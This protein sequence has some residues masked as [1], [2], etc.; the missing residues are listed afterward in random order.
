[1]SRGGGAVSSGQGF[2]RTFLWCHSMLLDVVTAT[3]SQHSHCDSSICIAI[4]SI[5]MDV[6]HPLWKSDCLV[7]RMFHPLCGKFDLEKIGK[8]S[9]VMSWSRSQ[10]QWLM[11]RRSSEALRDPQLRCIPMRVM[12][13]MHLSCILKHCLALPFTMNAFLGSVL[14]SFAGRSSLCKSHDHSILGKNLFG[15]VGNGITSTE[16]G[17]VKVLDII[18]MF[19][20]QLDPAL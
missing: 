13:V 4:W 15:A 9:P 7:H 18:K 14:Q 10:C 20:T 16:G 1:M 2:G 8:S 5:K 12:C 11:W 19:A 17:A 6:K 3:R